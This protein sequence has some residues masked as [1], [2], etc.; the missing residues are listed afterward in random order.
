MDISRHNS[1][2][3][4]LDKFAQIFNST[5][6]NMSPVELS[7]LD[8]QI[9]VMN[10]TL[11]QGLTTL[12]WSSQRIPNFITTVFHAIEKF[13][14]KLGEVRKHLA[15]IE[16]IVQQI[17]QFSLLDEIITVFSVS[18]LGDF[19]ETIEQLAKDKVSRSLQLY[20]SISQILIEVEVCVSE[21]SDNG[22]STLLKCS[23]NYWSRR[24]YNA[25]IEM[26][27]RSMFD[28]FKVL[29][30]SKSKTLPIN[31]IVTDKQVASEP[32]ISDFKKYFARCARIVT[33]SSRL[34]PRWMRHTCLNIEGV[35]EST[36]LTEAKQKHTFYND[37]SQNVALLSTFIGLNTGVHLLR[38]DFVTY[39][40]N[41]KD[42][43][44]KYYTV[45]AQWKAEL[46]K[47]VQS[48]QSTALFDQM[49]LECDR[50][51]CDI[52]STA[53]DNI[54]LPLSIKHSLCLFQ[55]IISNDVKSFLQ[56][57]L[58]E[59]KLDIADSLQHVGRQTLETVKTSIEN[60]SLLLS[61][62]P[63]SFDEFKIIMNGISTIKSMNMSI[64]LL[65]KDVEEKFIVLCDCN[66][67]VPL[68][69]I[70]EAKALHSQWY[71]TVVH[72][73][74]VELRLHNFKLNFKLQLSSKV[75][76]FESKL[77]EER[78]R[79]TNEGPGTPTLSLENGLTIF[80]EWKVKLD[81]LQSMKNTLTISEDLLDVIQ[82]TEFPDLQF[83]QESMAELGLIY[84]L[85]EDLQSLLQTQKSV[86][87]QNIN[88]DTFDQT[89][90]TY[91][92][93]MMMDVPRHHNLPIWEK[94]H[95]KIVD[96][97][98][99]LHILQRL[100][101]E[102][103]RD[104]HWRKLSDISNCSSNVQP[105]IAQVSFLRILEMDVQ[106]M[107]VEV[108]NIINSSLQEQKIENGLFH[109]INHWSAICLD[110]KNYGGRSRSSL[111]L[112]SM[113]ET[114]I[115]L[116]DHMLNLQTMLTSKFYGPF[117]VELKEWEERLNIFNECL[118]VWFTL[119]QKWMYLESI[120]VGTDDIRLQL[121]EEA[122][123]FDETSKAFQAI[124]K[125]VL[126]IP[127]IGINCT[128]DNLGIFIQLLEA[129]ERCQKALSEYLN[130]KRIAFARF[131]FISDE[132]MINI[133]GVV[134]EP[135]SVE[136]HLM[137][138][139]E[140]I[141]ILGFSECNRKIIE[142]QSS[143]G[144]HL[145][146]NKEVGCTGPVEIWM[147]HLEDEISSSLHGT[148]K[149]SIYTHAN[150]PLDKW[151]EANLGMCTISSSHIWWTWLVEDS[152]NSIEDGD[153]EAMQ[154]LLTELNANL[155]KMVKMTRAS[156]NKNTRRKVNSLLIIDVHA[157]DVVSSFVRDSIM[158]SKQFE[159][160]SQLRFYWDK[161]FDD[162]RIEQC[163]GSFSFGYEYL[164]LSGRLVITPLTNRCYMTLTQALTFKLG[165]SLSG[166]AG[167]GKVSSLVGMK[168]ELIIQLLIK[169][170]LMYTF[171]ETNRPKQSKIWPKL[172]ECHVLL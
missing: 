107:S 77:K 109:I 150:Q 8:I 138:L 161:Q 88:I 10:D 108:D 23:Y 97:R 106:A 153:Q 21:E 124:M 27:C 4:N 40:Q 162:M 147:Q 73:K 9:K 129:L 76:E 78:S 92:Q 103:I 154:S 62:E 30:S 151:I 166:P 67:V 160:E 16:V 29:R 133:L 131:Y 41:W 117:Q 74:T 171:H 34:F 125:K 58:H 137:K 119:Q 163:I 159:W 69:D 39:L 170:I 51:L 123:I 65:C 46:D 157:R 139:F 168:F 84:Q 45:D 128:R 63:S 136:P 122:I 118:L 102:S 135:M 75:N 53:F 37:V 1:Y 158:S 111:I 50:D 143:D 15:S 120:F 59:R 72:A 12:K 156:L 95:T 31:I 52:Q 57:A 155:S 99:N 44:H 55:T 60:Y 113:D 85:F 33:E 32:T 79:Y 28:F 140:N 11:T 148:M 121:P 90:S 20:R 112:N 89:V 110:V 87:W 81:S 100:R 101:G 93:N 54:N 164:G 149:Q 126:E 3:I 83:I 25:I 19:A 172:L 98:N 91:L 5:F 105:P 134:S 70:A 94:L 61:S 141:K 104:R 22:S 130:T 127:V 152:F 64:E 43:F 66:F 13:R 38:R 36:Y 47:V 116:E 71:N 7:L 167:T 6:D 115:Q 24:L 146:L 132:D 169:T 68:E 165:G 96:L 86:T 144:E 17:A 14:S 18:S 48:N 49:I 35:V 80:E 142:I 26:S 114:F 2:V 56:E 42:F 145:P 82:N